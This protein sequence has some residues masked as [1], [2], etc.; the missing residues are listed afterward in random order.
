MKNISEYSVVI[1]HGASAKLVKK[2]EKAF[3]YLSSRKEI[4]MRGAKLLFQASWILLL[5]ISAVLVLYSSLS[6]YRAYFSLQD[7]LYI[8]QN[9]T[10]RIAVGME[11][12]REK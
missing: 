5:A 2:R 7:Y 4:T 1:C 9:G 10:T 3:L 12:I 6:L 11:E 8:G